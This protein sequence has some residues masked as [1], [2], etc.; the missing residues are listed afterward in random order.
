MDS[1]TCKTDGV[2]IVADDEENLQDIPKVL[3]EDLTKDDT[4]LNAKT[5]AV[6]EEEKDT[7]ERW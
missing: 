7:N 5:M 1:G 6:A 2:A 3:N 4:K